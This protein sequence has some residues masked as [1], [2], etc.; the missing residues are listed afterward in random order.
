MVKAPHFLFQLLLYEV[1]G[2]QNATYRDAFIQHIV[3]WLPSGVPSGVA[4]SQ[5]VPYTPKGLAYENQHP[6][7]KSG[8]SLQF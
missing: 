6:L 5:R 1:T 3:Y 2:L 4:T 7:A 8:L